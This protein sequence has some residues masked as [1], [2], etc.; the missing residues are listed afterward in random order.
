MLV[1]RNRYG[2]SSKMKHVTGTGFIDSLSSIFNSI[3]EYAAPMFKS[4]GNYVA[5]NK[6]K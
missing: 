1:N 2:F 6:G 4:V 3:E 5:D